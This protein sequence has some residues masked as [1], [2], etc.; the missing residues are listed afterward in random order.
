MKIETIRRAGF[1][2]AVAVALLFGARAA[3]AD[4]DSASVQ[5]EY[6]F[7]RPTMAECFSACQ[8]QGDIVRRYNK[9]TG[10]CCCAGTN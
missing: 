5:G 1:G 4:V 2:A 7:Y 9:D 3:T 8:N 6:C 10:E